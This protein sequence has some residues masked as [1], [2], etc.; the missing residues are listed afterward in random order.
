[1]PAQQDCGLC[2]CLAH[3][4]ASPRKASR[5]SRPGSLRVPAL[6]LRRV[7]WQRMSFSE[8]LVC[9][10]I[11]GGSSTTSNSASL[12]CRR[13]SNRSSVTKPVGT[14]GEDATEAGAQPETAAF[15]WVGPVN[16]Q[17]GIEVPDQFA[18]ALLSRTRQIGE[19]VQLVHQPFRMDPAQSM[20]ADGELPGIVTH[21]NPH[22]EG[23]SK[24]RLG[25][26]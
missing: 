3:V 12:A 25:A 18:H 17:I 16:L 21:T 13:F 22:K 24:D 10:G 2:R 9:S 1:M 5:Q 14:A 26:D 15:A 23:L 20:P 7:T 19:G 6:T 11:S 8:P 4:L